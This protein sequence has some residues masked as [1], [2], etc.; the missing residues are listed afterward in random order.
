MSERESP[1]A[2]PEVSPRFAQEAAA[3]L[4]AGD[5]AGALALARAGTARYPWYP[6]G[7]LILGRCLEA[8]GSTPEAM[9]AF[10]DAGRLLPDAPLLAELMAARGA[11]P[12]AC[13]GR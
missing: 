13:A 9:A 10:R 12:A 5:T 2:R 11:A 1:E 8:A 4:A 7:H 6:T 3:L